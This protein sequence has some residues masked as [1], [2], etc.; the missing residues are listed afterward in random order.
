MR[1][2]S[3][4]KDKDISDFGYIGHIFGSNGQIS[5]KESILYRTWDIS[6][7]IFCVQRSDDPEEW[8]NT[9]KTGLRVSHAHCRADRRVPSYSFLSRKKK[10][11]KHPES[12]DRRGRHRPFK[13]LWVL[14]S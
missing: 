11:K 12:S 8:K 13:R 10:Y 3:R 7:E 1:Q 14:L 9:E 6:V 4:T 5:L 2:H